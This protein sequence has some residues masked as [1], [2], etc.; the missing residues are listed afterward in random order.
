MRW[1]GRTKHGA[2]VCKKEPTPLAIVT[3]VMVNKI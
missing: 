1:Y 3:R 2:Y